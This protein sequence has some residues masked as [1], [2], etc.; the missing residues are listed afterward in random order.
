[1][2]KRIASVFLFVLLISVAATFIS[3]QENSLSYL[4]S[5]CSFIGR[6]QMSRLLNSDLLAEQIKMNKQMNLYNEQGLGPEQI[7]DIYFGA[8]AKKITPGIKMDQM[9][10]AII[11]K[12]EKK[13]SLDNLIKKLKSIE[14]KAIQ[15]IRETTVGGKKVYLLK[16]NNSESYLAELKKG[17]FCVAGKSMLNKVFKLQQN[18]GK[19]IRNNSEMMELCSSGN[20]NHMLWLAGFIPES[21]KKSPAA[22]AQNP[23]GQPPK[24]DSIFIYLNLTKK[25]NIGGRIKCESSA[26]AQKLAMQSKMFSGMLTMDPENGINPQDIKITPNNK[27]VD[28]DVNISEKALKKLSKKAAQGMMTS[29]S[30]NKMQTPPSSSGKKQKKSIKI[31]RPSEMK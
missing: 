9:D 8:K 6:I 26:A 3:A 27:F 29:C 7:E 19:S 17:L 28:L 20:N 24:L 21:A 31:K 18:D 2:M 1:M 16:D 14:D 5:D 13:K 22:S 25:L 12:H 30:S 11:I 15:N 10:Y 23:M 4:P